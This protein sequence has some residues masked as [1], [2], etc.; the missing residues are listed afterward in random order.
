MEG[1][2]RGEES[3]PGESEGSDLENRVGKRGVRIGNFIGLRVSV[4]SCSG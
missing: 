4:V 3:W 2:R 1:K